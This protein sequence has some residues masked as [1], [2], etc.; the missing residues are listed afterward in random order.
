MKTG[1]RLAIWQALSEKSLYPIE[2]VR[3]QQNS[4]HD[5]AAPTIK[6]RRK[7]GGGSNPASHRLLHAGDK[8]P[9]GSDRSTRL[10]RNRYCYLKP[11]SAA[12][13][14]ALVFPA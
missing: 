8:E 5:L 12:L 7:G 2:Q 11:R 9:P 10:S 6:E 3:R 14:I 4:R 1:P 13:T